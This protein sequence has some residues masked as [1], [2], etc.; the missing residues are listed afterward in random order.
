LRE[1]PSQ[2]LLLVFSLIGEKK[3]IYLIVLL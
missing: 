3:C 1:E 2:Q